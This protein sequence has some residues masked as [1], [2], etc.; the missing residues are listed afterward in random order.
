MTDNPMRDADERREFADKMADEAD[1]PRTLA[2]LVAEYQIWTAANDHP[3]AGSA[4][5]LLLEI[6]EEGHN[7]RT[8]AEAAETRAAWL[9]DFITRWEKA[10]DAESD[11]A[12]FEAWRAQRKWWHDLRDSPVADENVTGPGYEYDGLYI[13]LNIGSSQE[14]GR[15]WTM[16]P[17]DLWGDL[18][19]CERA[20]WESN[21]RDH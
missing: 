1:R 20:L 10:Q 2:E 15:Y 3:E 5:E 17:F 11:T 6:Y 4:D 8:R 12:R 13:C 21:G 9:K 18:D 14:L 19:K 7:H 16:C